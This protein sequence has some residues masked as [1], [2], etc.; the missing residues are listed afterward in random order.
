M[1][2]RKLCAV[3]IGIAIKKE[4]KQSLKTFSRM[5]VSSTWKSSSAPDKLNQWPNYFCTGKVTQKEYEECLTEICIFISFL[6]LLF[7]T[8]TL[9]FMDKGKGEKKKF[10]GHMMHRLIKSESQIC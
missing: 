7:S 4:K 6:N 3:K 8:P 5:E 9:I 2:K 1:F 10:K